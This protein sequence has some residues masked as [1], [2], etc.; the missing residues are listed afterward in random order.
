MISYYIFVKKY[1]SG[2]NLPRPASS[3]PEEVR[4]CARANLWK[5]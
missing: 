1:Y 4:V 2:K 5:M 3:S